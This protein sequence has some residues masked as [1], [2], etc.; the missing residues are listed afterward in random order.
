MWM[1]RTG[2]CVVIAVAWW[3]TGPA[4]AADSVYPAGTTVDAYAGWTNAVSL[5]NGE[6]LAVIVPSA[7]GRAL[8]YALH[9]QNILFLSPELNGK[10]LADLNGSWAHGGHQID[11]GPELRGMPPHN[12]LWWGEYAWHI[13]GP[14]AV[15]VT[16]KPDPGAGVQITKEFTLD[17]DSGDL[18]VLQTIKN[19]SEQLVKYCLWDRTLCLNSGFAVIPLNLKSQFANHWALRVKDAQGNWQY[20]GNARAPREVKVIKNHLV[21]SCQG[22]ATKVGADSTA[23]WIAYVRGNLLFVKYFPYFGGGEYTDGGCSTEVYFDERVAEMEPLSPEVEMKP[24][25]SFTFPE[26]WTLI[27]LGEMVSTPEQ[28]QRAVRRIAPSPFR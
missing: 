14:Y 20:D 5:D 23:G 18:G 9:H 28:A 21:V 26:K 1:L 12:D 24:G 13:S 27:E 15:R 17:R 8:R 25:E 22:P 16:S 6:A 2:W 7:G 19:T 10:T 4:V 11:I 3:R